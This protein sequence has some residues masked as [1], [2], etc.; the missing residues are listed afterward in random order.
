MNYV[1][2]NPFD[3]YKKQMEEMQEQARKRIEEINQNSIWEDGESPFENIQELKKDFDDLIPIFSKIADSS[4]EQV[5]SIKIIADNAVKQAESAKTIADRAKLEI[6][7]LSDTS[8]SAKIKANR[9]FWLA[10]ASFGFSILINLDK[11]VNAV[12]WIKSCLYS[13]LCLG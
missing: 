11:I 12:K 2:H 3:D 6:E 8:L 5:E 9:S 4:I 1:I 10:F 7:K 13:I